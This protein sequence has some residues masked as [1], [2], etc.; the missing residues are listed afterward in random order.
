MDMLNNKPVHCVFILQD[1]YMEFFLRFPPHPILMKSKDNSINNNK[2]ELD[3][4]E[5]VFNSS[6]HKIK[7]FLTTLFIKIEKECLIDTVTEDVIS[8]MV[9]TINNIDQVSL[10]AYLYPHIKLSISSNSQLI[11]IFNILEHFDRPF[12]LEKYSSIHKI[13]YRSDVDSVDITSINKSVIKRFMLM[14]GNKNIG[15]FFGFESNIN[16]IK[17]LY[18]IPNDME[19]PICE[20]CAYKYIELDNNRLIT[21]NDAI[22]ICIISPLD[23]FKDLEYEIIDSLNDTR[24]TF[25]SNMLYKD[26]HYNIFVNMNCLCSYYSDGKTRKN[27]CLKRIPSRNDSIMYIWYSYLDSFLNII[28]TID[29][30]NSKNDE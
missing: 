9:Y 28:G 18:D 11:D 15:K 3:I 16:I 26:K 13:F 22:M 8:N 6:I 20:T 12:L 23:Y 14:I 2:I 24:S 29:I 17:Y 30:P 5:F 21:S 1:E 19:L 10:C 27:I 4:N 25:N 7:E